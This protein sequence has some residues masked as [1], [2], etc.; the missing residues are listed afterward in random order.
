MGLREAFLLRIAKRWISGVDLD[1]VVRDSKRAN[2]SGYGV[3][4]NYLGEEIA[5]QSVAD[6]H[7]KHYIDL[8][9]AIGENGIRG[10][11]S[12]KLTQFGLG[13]GEAST[14][15]RLDAVVT[16]AERLNQKLW[17]DMEGSKFTTPTIEIY[18]RAVQKYR[19]VGVAIQSY[20]KRSEADLKSLIERGGRI[21]L[22]KGAYHE[23][24]ELAFDTRTEV[25]QSFLKLMKMLFEGSEG[26]AIATH[27][28]FLI[29]NA[30]KLADSSHTDFEFEMLKGI[31]NE[32]KEELVA[33]GYKVSEYLPYGD[34]WYHYS[35]R[36]MQ[37]HPSNLILL[38]RSLI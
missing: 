1:S 19:G 4:A 34:Q 15:K 9:N 30:R 33:S 36:R 10:C 29:D 16:N 13:T 22:V 26:F 14:E 28:S 25:N 31:R 6:S 11:A 37:E 23:P 27:N 2:K 35:M 24:H 21:R 20:L 5:D 7:L 3:V 12:V 17:I 38:L 32:L 8:Q 18:E